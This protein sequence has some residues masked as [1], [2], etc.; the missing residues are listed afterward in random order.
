MQCEQQ[1][2]DQRTRHV[3]AGHQRA[4]ASVAVA[5]ALEVARIDAQREHLARIP[6]APLDLRT[7]RQDADAQR[8]RGRGPEAFVVQAHLEARR[9]ADV[10]RDAVANQ[11]AL[12]VV[13]GIGGLVFED[14]AFPAGL[15][16]KPAAAAVDADRLA[17]AL[18]ALPNAHDLSL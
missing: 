4:I 2:R 18:H 13:D 16:E 8:L 11:A 14:H 12:G 5:G 1:L 10:D 9:A 7:R 17:A 15:E 6:G 3:A